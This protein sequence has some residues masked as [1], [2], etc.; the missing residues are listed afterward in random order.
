MSGIGFTR[1]ECCFATI[2]VLFVL[3]VYLVRTEVPIPV[4]TFT[5]ICALTV[6]KVE[7]FMMCIQIHCRNDNMYHLVD[8]F[9]KQV[10]HSGD[11]KLG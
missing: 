11:G 7:D 4:P 1:H 9:N 10:T 6:E 3:N 2:L 5:S 8:E